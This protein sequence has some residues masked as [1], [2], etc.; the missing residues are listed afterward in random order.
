MGGRIS[1]YGNIVRDG[2]V[3]NLDAGKIDSYPRTGTLWRDL[4]G[5]GNNGT[6][7]NFNGQFWG[8]NDTGSIL[9]DG[10]DSFVNFSD[11]PFRI[12]NYSL[13]L[14]I[15]FYYSGGTYTN[16]PLIG[17]RNGG[18]APFNQYTIGLNNGDPYN[19]G[20]GKVLV[21][22]L[23]DDNNPNSNF[24]DRVLTY[25]LPTAGIYHVMLTNASNQAQL[26]VNGVLRST[27]TTNMASGNFN[28]TGY[29]FR[30]GNY[31][32]ALYWNEKIYLTRFYNK[33]LSNSEITQNYNAIKSRFNI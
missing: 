6:L 26:W 14:E 2:L 20:T 11:I 1:Y 9:F 30:I 33:T 8:S 21:A 17:K 32:T 22:F 5:N 16:T 13:T 12:T 7:T 24:N 4:S 15:V 25:T 29:N 18:A 23:R 27:S 19:G 3:L 31:Y 10:T 28:V